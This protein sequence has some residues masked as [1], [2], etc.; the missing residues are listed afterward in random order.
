MFFWQN[1]TGHGG[2][3]N[4]GGMLVRASS[5]DDFPGV[6]ARQVQ[7]ILVEAVVAVVAVVLVDASPPPLHHNQVVARTLHH[8]KEDHRKTC[9]RKPTGRKASNKYIRF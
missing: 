6:A 9:L 3:P 1:I 4:K 7:P 8:A 5:R 2:V